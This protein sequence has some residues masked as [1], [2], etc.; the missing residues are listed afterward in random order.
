VQRRQH[1]E[2]RVYER[3][4]NSFWN[5]PVSVCEPTVRFEMPAAGQSKLP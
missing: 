3:A 5:R 1:V 4:L 2:G